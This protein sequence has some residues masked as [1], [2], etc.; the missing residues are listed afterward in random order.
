MLSDPE[1]REKYDATGDVQREMT[2]RQ[3]AEALVLLLLNSAL[4]KSALK[5]SYGATCNPLWEM[6][7]EASEILSKDR[8]GHLQMTATRRQ[9]QS[10]LLLF[11]RQCGENMLAAAIQQRIEG[12]DKY[13]EGNASHQE[14]MLEVLD[15][16]KGYSYGADDVPDTAAK[17]WPQINN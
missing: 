12:A 7:R 5:T 9:L 16:L 3:A 15:V 1:R 10:M 8:E 2:K 4:E 6:R 17:T 14:L 13:L 11:K